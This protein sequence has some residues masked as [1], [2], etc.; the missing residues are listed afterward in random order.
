MI[1]TTNW[2]ESLNRR[3]KRT[4][5]IRASFPNECSALNLVCAMLMGICENNYNKY[6]ITSLLSEK[7]K[8]DVKLEEMKGQKIAHNGVGEVDGRLT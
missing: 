1:Y 7:D 6:K 3:I 4:T 5:K 2:L 8:L